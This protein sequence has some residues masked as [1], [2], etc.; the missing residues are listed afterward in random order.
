MLVLH[1]EQDLRRKFQCALRWLFLPGHVEMPS[2]FAAIPQLS[3]YAVY[4]ELN[5]Y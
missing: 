2:S 3:E 4:S 1:C 5:V